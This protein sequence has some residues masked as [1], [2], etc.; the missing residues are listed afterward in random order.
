MV[1]HYW[2]LMRSLIFMNACNVNIYYLIDVH[3]ND[4]LMR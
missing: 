3:G 1:A 2:S 4:E